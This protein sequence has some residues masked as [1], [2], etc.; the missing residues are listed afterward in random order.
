MGVL[1]T[2][3]Q[4]S[5]LVRSLLTGS[6][7]HDALNL[8]RHFGSC[9]RTWVVLVLPPRV[10]L[11]SPTSRCLST[12][13]CLLCESARATRGDALSKTRWNLFFSPR[14][15]GEGLQDAVY[16][17]RWVLDYLDGRVSCHGNNRRELIRLS[18]SFVNCET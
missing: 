6:S 12:P 18:T 2:L 4:G 3:H 1:Q 17:S 8:A 7:T 16:G 15:W 11:R 5:S 14:G 13:A 10:A 9:T